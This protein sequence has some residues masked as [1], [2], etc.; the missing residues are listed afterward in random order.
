MSL[1]VFFSLFLIGGAVP[2]PMAFADSVVVEVSAVKANGLSLQNVRDLSFGELVTN[3]T[4]EISESSP[5][6]GEVLVE[7]SPD[8]PITVWFSASAGGAPT[9]Q[10][11]LTITGVGTDTMTATNMGVV[12]NS[13]TAI[14]NEVNTFCDAD[15]N[16]SIFVIGEVTVGDD[17]VNPAGEYTGDAYI[18][19][20]LG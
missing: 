10:L 12:V 13:E 20:I 2:P 14:G 19:V 7:T 5:N 3:Q 9:S 4:T 16:C 6:A 11:T 8:A 1:L 18:N 17:T 15:G